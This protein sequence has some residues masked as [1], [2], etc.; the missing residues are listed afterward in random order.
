MMRILVVSDSDRLTDGLVASEVADRLVIE[1]TNLQDYVGRLSAEIDYVVIDAAS[2]PALDILRRIR[3]DYDVPVTIASYDDTAPHRVQAFDAGADDY[4]PRAVSAR[5]LVARMQAVLRRVPQA[6]AREF[7]VVDDAALRPA[8]NVVEVGTTPVQLTG[9]E[10]MILRMLMMHAG[11]AVSRE[12]L[13]RSALNR[14]PSGL[15]RSLDTHVSNLRRKMGPS[16]AG[17]PRILSVR[18]LGYQ[19]VR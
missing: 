11:E 12:A 15:D 10:A 7:I 4:L 6:A 16:S 8:S 13:Y 3:D 17:A 2:E 19:Y 5:E 18:G 9:I 14:E 1:R